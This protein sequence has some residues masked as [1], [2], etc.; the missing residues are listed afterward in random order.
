MSISI[1]EIK[2]LEF[3]IELLEEHIC[4]LTQSEKAWYLLAIE[5]LKEQKMELEDMFTE[6]YSDTLYFKYWDLSDY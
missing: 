2:T 3:Y 4:E 6:A 1:K 5:C